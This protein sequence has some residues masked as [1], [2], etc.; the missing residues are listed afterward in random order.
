M[1]VLSDFWVTTHSG[2]IHL[3]SVD[4]PSLSLQSDSGSII[5]TLNSEKIFEV[6]TRSGKVAVPAS[7]GNERCKITTKSGNVTLDIE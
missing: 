2:D 5:G 4:S 1:C 6:S 3:T 7:R